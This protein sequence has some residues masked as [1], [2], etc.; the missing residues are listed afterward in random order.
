MCICY[1][2]RSA[3]FKSGQ[4]LL[5]P[6][7][8]I[9]DSEMHPAGFEIGPAGL[10]SG[11][12]CLKSGL[13]RFETGILWLTRLSHHT[14]PISSVSLRKAVSF[15]VSCS[16]LAIA[17][18]YERIQLRPNGAHYIYKASHYTLPCGVSLRRAVSFVVSCSLLAIAMSYE[19]LQLRRPTGQAR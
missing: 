15:V 1:L 11:L 5:K 8:L 18:S 13:A 7:I 12:A 9:K 19:R 6:A 4:P 10:K 2:S 17:L 16:L 3:S 14:L